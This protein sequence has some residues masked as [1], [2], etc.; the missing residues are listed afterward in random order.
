MTFIAVLSLAFVRT[1]FFDLFQVQGDLIVGVETLP[2]SL[3]E[4][5][6]ITLLK[7]IIA[8]AAA[9]LVMAPL[10]GF[11]NTFSLLLI[12]CF[13]TLSVCLTAYEKRK[14][15]PG[16]FL[17]AVVEGNLFFAGFLGLIWHIL[18]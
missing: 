18:S 14:I 3:G 15:Y 7:W 8:A 5:R 9:V 4:K 10:L 17:E 16:P 2:I 11:V 13:F 12:A 6:T 1:A